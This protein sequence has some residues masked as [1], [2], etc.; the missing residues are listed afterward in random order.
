MGRSY[1]RTDMSDAPLQLANKE[2]NAACAFISS[3]PVKYL[4]AR[5]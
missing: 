1:P 3:I 5:Q 2:G 4:S